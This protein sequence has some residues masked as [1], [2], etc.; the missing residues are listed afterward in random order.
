MLSLLLGWQFSTCGSR[1][2]WSS[3][4]GD[5]IEDTP[6][7]GERKGILILVSWHRKEIPMNPLGQTASVDYGKTRKGTRPGS[8]A[9]L[10]LQPMQWPS[11][12]PVHPGV[13]GVTVTIIVTT[14]SAGQLT[15]VT[16]FLDLSGF[17]EGEH[18]PVGE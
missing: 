14:R 11:R 8:K 4:S 18:I 16:A 2:L 15:G 17:S 9:S 12:D 3:N 10:S 1:P 5:L 7:L 6:R 13:I